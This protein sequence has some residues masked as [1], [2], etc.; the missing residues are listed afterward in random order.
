MAAVRRP[1]PGW[2]NWYMMRRGW[3]RM[4]ST[5]AIA[6]GIGSRSS[7]LSPRGKVRGH[8]GIGGWMGGGTAAL[9]GLMSI[10]FSVQCSVIKETKGGVENRFVKA[11][12]ERM[13]AKEWDG[14]PGRANKRP[15]NPRELTAEEQVANEPG[16]EDAA[17]G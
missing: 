1:Q 13:V 15:K 16:D 17:G 4:A 5:A 8:G 2:R 10:G 12:C 7:G 9:V 3:R 14:Q 11:A 6:L